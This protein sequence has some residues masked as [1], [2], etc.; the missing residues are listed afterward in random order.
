MAG[1][2]WGSCCFRPQNRRRFFWQVICV[3][4]PRLGAICFMFF[5]HVNIEWPPRNESHNTKGWHV[6]AK[7]SYQVFS[8]ISLLFV[9]RHQFLFSS[10]TT[11]SNNATNVLLMLRETYIKTIRWVIVIWP[12]IHPTHC[13]WYGAEAAHS[14]Q[15]LA[16]ER[17]CDIGT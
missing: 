15:R 14:R 12:W 2:L 4:H 3:G 9:S 13:K 10:T 17:I 5:L 6:V 7:S 1:Q 11:I 16:R 8:F